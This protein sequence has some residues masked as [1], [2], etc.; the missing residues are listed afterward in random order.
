MLPTVSAPRLQ[1][2]IHILWQPTP[3][4]LPGESHGRRSL[5]GYS[6]WGRKE[7]DTPERLHS[8]THSLTRLYM[9]VYIC[10]RLYMLL[11]L[12]SLSCLPF[13]FTHKAF[14]TKMQQ[15]IQPVGILF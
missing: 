10:A 3:V 7:S 15:A 8:L 6:A 1:L 13:K 9:Y 4:L 5:V 12:L 2:Y 11:N 14:I